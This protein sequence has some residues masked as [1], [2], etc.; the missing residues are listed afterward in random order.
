VIYKRKTK[1]YSLAA[2]VRTLFYPLHT[3][4]LLKHKFALVPNSHWHMD[5]CLMNNES[6]IFYLCKY[7]LHLMGSLRSVCGCR[8]RPSTECCILLCNLFKNIYI[9][10]WN[11]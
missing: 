11:C 3:G 10:L 6:V 8:F 1:R 2:K 5:N 7:N 9:L 4:F